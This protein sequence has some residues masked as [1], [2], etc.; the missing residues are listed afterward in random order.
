MQRLEILDL[1]EMGSREGP[2]TGRGGGGGG[3]P[4]SY[5]TQSLIL[6]YFFASGSGVGWR[7]VESVGAGVPLVDL[8]LEDVEVVRGCY[9]DDVFMGV[10]RRVEDFLAEV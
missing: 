7:G 5:L 4:F 3:V 10:P 6:F 9:S 1:Q 2:H 8:V